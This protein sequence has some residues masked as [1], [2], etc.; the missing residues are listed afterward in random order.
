MAFAL[1]LVRDFISGTSYS[2]FSVGLAHVQRHTR[3]GPPG[4]EGKIKV[5][6]DHSNSKVGA[7]KEKKEL[8]VDQPSKS[9]GHNCRRWPIMCRYVCLC[10]KYTF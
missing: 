4:K 2:N 6:Q 3:T 5:Y 10:L 9:G 8:V 1:A 7:V